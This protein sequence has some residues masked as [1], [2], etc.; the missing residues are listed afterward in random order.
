MILPAS[1]DL[2][3]SSFEVYDE[4]NKFILLEDMIQDE[5]EIENII[6]TIRGKFYYG[7]KQI[8]S[9]DLI[10]DSKYPEIY[11]LVEL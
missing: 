3:I 9:I 8:T 11:K 6:D 1:I 7:D 2:I 10:E 4:N 5:R